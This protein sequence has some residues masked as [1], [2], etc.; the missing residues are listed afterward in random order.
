MKFDGKILVIGCGAV[1]QCALPLL[2]ELVDVPEKNITIMDTLDNRRYIK[3]ILARGARYIRAQVVKENYVRLF[4]KYVGPG[5]MIIDLA[6]DIDCCAILQWCRD[7]QVLYVNAS[8][9]LWHPYRGAEGK[10]PTELTLYA[11]HMAI[12]EMMGTWPDNKGATAVLDHGANPGLVSHFTKQALIDIA[13]KILH[14]KPTDSRKTNLEKAL[15]NENFAVLAQLEEVK[16]IHISERDTQI[17]TK[18]KEVNEFVNTWSIVG[19]HEEGVAPAELGWGTHERYTPKGA[20]FHK[21][22]CAINFVSEPKE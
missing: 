5:D 10:H 22:A 20:M 2:L 15:Q 19:F 18:P 21:K 7:Q 14:E 8:V 11:R 6:Y 1:S 12:R 13:K 17:T 9:E 4:E 16:V 3:K